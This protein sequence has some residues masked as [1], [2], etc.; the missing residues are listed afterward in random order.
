MAYSTKK[1]TTARAPLLKETRENMLLDQK[2]PCYIWGVCQ[3][4]TYFYREQKHR[5][6][7]V[8]FIESSPNQAE[9]I[10]LPVFSPIVLNGTSAIVFVAPEILANR[11]AIF[12]TLIG[13]G[14]QKGKDFFEVGEY[15]DAYRQHYAEN[16][17]I[18]MFTPKTEDS[19]TIVLSCDENYAPYAGVVIESILK[20]RTVT[21]QYEFYVLFTRL[22]KDTQARFSQLADENITVTCV[23]L[24]TEIISLQKSFQATNHVTEEAYYR[25]LIPRIFTNF[26]KILYLDCD[27]ICCKN[28]EQMYDV[29]LSGYALGAVHSIRNSLKKQFEFEGYFNSGVMLFHISECKN[30]NLLTKCFSLLEEETKKHQPGDRPFADQDVLN[31]TFS[32]SIFYLDDYWNVCQ[33]APELSPKITKSL[34]NPGIVHYVSSFKPWFYL[35]LASSH[36]FWKIAQNSIFFDMILEQMKQRKMKE[37]LTMGCQ[38]SWAD[39]EEEIKGEILEALRP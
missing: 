27:V 37:L 32:G 33:R 25:V 2:T 5:F 8:G 24:T 20:H 26:R 15:T 1:N 29:D 35:R 22:S 9:F 19:V 39:V 23:N 36:Y 18:S 30:Q 14:L 13:K 3:M 7:I 34:E 21:R 11:Q 28:V 16:Y 31:M 4:A 12:A 17:P 10:G 6:N 38:V